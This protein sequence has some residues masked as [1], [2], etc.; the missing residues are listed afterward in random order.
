MVDLEEKMEETVYEN[1]T[2]KVAREHKNGYDVFRAYAYTENGTVATS[3]GCTRSKA[4]AGL[5]L[6]LKENAA[7][8]EH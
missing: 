8:I 3:K 2:I 6:A 7:R 5:F 4:L 1:I